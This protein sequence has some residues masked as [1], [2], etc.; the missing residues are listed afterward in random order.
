[1]ER[2]EKQRRQPQAITVP[3]RCAYPECGGKKMQV[4]Q[5]VVKRLRDTG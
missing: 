4:R 1:M 2:R 5:M 3:T